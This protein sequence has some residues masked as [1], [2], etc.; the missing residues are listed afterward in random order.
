VVVVEVALAVPEL[1]LEVTAI[2]IIQGTAVLEA[3]VV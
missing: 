3:T 1:M 2:Q